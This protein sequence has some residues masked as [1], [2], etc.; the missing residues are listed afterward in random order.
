[1]NYKGGLMKSHEEHNSAVEVWGGI[2]CTVQRIGDKFGNQL[3]RNGHQHR[4]AD[5]DAIAELGVKKLRYPILWETVAP[6]GL[7]N[8]DW[9]W[10]DERMERL[11]QLGIVPIITLLHHGS[12]PAY[13]NLLDPAFAE[14]F[15]AFAVAV[16]ERYPWLEY[17]TPVNEP[18]TTA[19]FS[20]LYGLWYPHAQD[21]AKFGKALT[22]E[23]KATIL[24]MREIRKRIPSAKLVQTE[25]MGKCHGT[26]LLRY[27]WEIE[28]ERR[29]ASLD[30]LTGRV[31]ENEYIRKFFTPLASLKEDLTFF[32]QNVCPPDIIGINYYITSERFLDEDHEKY[33]AWAFG[34][35][36][37]HHYADVDIV[38]A[39]IHKREGHYRILKET[40]DRYQLPLALTEV[41]LGATRDE[42]MRWF[43]EAWKASLKLKRE[44]VDVQGITAWSLLGA[45]DWNT[46]LTK[47]DNFYET[48]AFDVSSGQLRPTALAHLLKSL[49]NGEEPVHPVLCADG[50]W[51][52]PGTVNFMF[53]TKQ[54][55]RQLTTVDDIDSALPSPTPKP[56]LITG[57]TG[58][59]GQAFAR[60][61]KIRNISYVLLSRKDMDIADRD[62]VGKM[63]A[64]YQPWAVINAAGFVKV[65]EAEL[66]PS[67]C[68]RENTDGAAVLAAACRRHDC[69]YLTFSTD[70][71]FSGDTRSAYR[72][73]DQ[74]RPL[75]IYGV[76]K[77]LA[78]ARVLNVHPSSIVV[79]TSSF[80]GPWDEHNFL[81]Q[82]IDALEQRRVFKTSAAFVVSPAYVPD[83]VNACLDLIIDG[84]K[85]VWHIAHPTAVSWRDLALT[86][87]EIAKLDTSLIRSVSP[88]VLGYRAMRPAYSALNSERGLMMPTLESAINRCLLERKVEDTLLRA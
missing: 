3:E 68:M 54:E 60:I 80:F 12:G 24:A 84:E 9:S 83:L 87:A 55:E 36:G 38:R 13:T 2:E 46:L 57:A 66:N 37:K 82:M 22:N 44:G 42:Q 74:A 20:C 49:C 81:A 4:L 32:R 28:N 76:S 88:E 67:V 14:K 72:E 29:W 65:D 16:A 58:T 27:Q 53:G 8:A 31:D 59:L 30:L 77:Y 78:E 51:K 69:A 6:D 45:F 64:Q 50:W 11:R 62:A 73:S 26:E 33:P 85:G 75:N 10:T 43:M 15:T 48:G 1:M 23:C 34:T 61:C 86:T 71:V 40:H 5:L 18:L 21:V 47:Q 39:D 79:R 70:L 56:I 17:F 25:D 63:L 52:T 41:H 19:R 7:G 35:N